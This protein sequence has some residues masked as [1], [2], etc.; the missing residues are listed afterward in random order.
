MKLISKGLPLS[1]VKQ[2][3]FCDIFGERVVIPSMEPVAAWLALWNQYILAE[4][5]KRMPGGSAC[6][7]AD[8]GP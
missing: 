1:E 7:A 6:I 2:L 3:L 5:K 8:R 4:V